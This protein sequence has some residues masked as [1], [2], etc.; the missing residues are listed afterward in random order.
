[1]STSDAAS[2]LPRHVLARGACN[3]RDLGGYRTN[4]GRR[5]RTGKVF[6]SGV[7]DQL[8]P[9]DPVVAELSMAVVID[10]R[11]G[12]ER[13]KRPSNLPEAWR[14]GLWARDYETS[15]GDHTTISQALSA[16]EIRAIMHKVYRKMPFEQAGSYRM[17]FGRLAAGD[18]PLLFH[19][20][21]G[22]DR[23][24]VGAALLLDV[25]GVPRPVVLADYALTEECLARD[26]SVIERGSSK[27]PPEVQLAR[28]PL[29]RADPA[30]LESMFDKLDKDFGGVEGYL[31][32]SLGVDH[33]ARD[34]IRELLLES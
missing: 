31:E 11:T 30:Y 23:T 16:D 13:T 24:G 34:R 17:L 28:A 22:K 21:G 12:R 6:R 7:L 8:D 33:A 18:L 2:D 5:V 19:C 9:G 27:V 20:H 26:K 15:G 1:M 14:A 32:E 29:M 25:L 10:L 4:D 3:F